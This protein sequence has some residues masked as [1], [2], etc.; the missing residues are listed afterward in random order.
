MEL[1]FFYEPGLGWD[2]YV[3][4]AMLWAGFALSIYALERM[5]KK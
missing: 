2:Y 5:R 3:G 1:L 4:V